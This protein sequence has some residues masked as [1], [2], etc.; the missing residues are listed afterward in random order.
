MNM[1]SKGQLYI[2][3]SVAGGG[4]S[5]LIN[6]LMEK[7]PD[8]KFSVSYTSRPKREGEKHGMNYYF[9][10]TKEFEKLL[11]EDFFF[12]WAK[13]H[14]NYYGTPKKFINEWLKE[15][16]KVILDIDVQGAKTV[17][18]SIQDAISIFIL[19]PD[20]K[21]WIERLTNRGTESKESLETRLKNGKQELK[22]SRDFD[23]QVINDNLE[24]AFNHLYN[25]IY[26]I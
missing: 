5:T 20:E 6:N 10:E 17:K 13:V 18:Q 14:N 7:D 26:S 3:S 24:E 2:I 8:L 21:T 15:G 22:H 12:E 11:E 25:I 16:K 1:K 4:K 23:H 9:V 19:P